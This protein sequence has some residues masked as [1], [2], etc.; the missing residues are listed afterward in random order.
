MR[1][2]LAAKYDLRV[3]RYTSYPTAPHFGPDVGADR[4]AEWLGAL[5]PDVP[6]SLYLHII[7]CAEMCSFCACH[8]KIT[9]RYEPVTDYLDCLWREVE[10]VADR[11]GEPRSVSHVHFGGGSPT[12]LTPADLVATVDKLRSRFKIL[13]NA[14]IA[15]ELDPRTADE[16]YVRAMENA[17]VTRASIG[18]QDFNPVVQKA[19][20]RI[21]PYEMTAEVIDWLRRHNISDINMDLIY[22]LPYQTVASVIETIDRA[23][24]LEPR[25][26]ALFGYAHVPWM[27]KHQRLIPESALPD[28]AERWRQY[29]AATARLVSFGYQAIGLDHFARADDPMAIAA[30]DSTLHRNFQGYTTDEAQALI[31]LGA[32]GIGALPQGYVA[33][34][35][36]LTAYKRT[37]RAGRLATTR[38]IAIDDD[39][40]L[41]RAIIER[42]MCGMEVDIDAICSKF[43]V[44]PAQFD[45]ELDSLA[46]MEA[47]GLLV[48]AGREL[49]M[50]DD[51]RALVRAAAAAFDRYLK[52]GEAR[53]SKAV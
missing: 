43:A 27:K 47:D 15:L 19:I 10:L 25:R 18:V 13:A 50:T 41:R 16:D 17:G 38:G 51:G 37:I 20:N 33:N 26:I 45:A 6:L 46:P 12:I 34:Q 42:L 48:R 5:P 53:H 9:K 14:E 28:V 36:D 3:P 21:Q 49:H 39:D 52:A 4:Y 44:D 22:G 2:D 1:P 29:E 24:G 32:S 23:A 7:Y 8:V 30:K 11:L 31:G 35:T 40:R